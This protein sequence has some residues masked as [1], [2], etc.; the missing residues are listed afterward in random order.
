MVCWVLVTV[1]EP[2]TVVA[3]LVAEHRLQVE[4][5][6]WLQCMGLAALRHV[7]SSQTRDQTRVQRIGRCSLYLSVFQL[8]KSQYLSTRVLV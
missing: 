8:R 4:E 5:L 1:H 3:S 6:Q 2:L 7:V